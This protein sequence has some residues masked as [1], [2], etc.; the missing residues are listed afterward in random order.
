MAR[1]SDTPE[2]RERKRQILLDELLPTVE[3]LLGERWGEPNCGPTLADVAYH[4]GYSVKA[5]EKALARLGL[6]YSEVKSLGRR[7]VAARRLINGGFL[8]V[9]GG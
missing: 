1:P 7:N 8:S 2:T 5:L 9:S 3:Y 6:R 4:T